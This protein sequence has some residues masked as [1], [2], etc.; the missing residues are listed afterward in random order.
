MA[1]T[2][3]VA[4][5]VV[6]GFLAGGAIWF[7]TDIRGLVGE[8]A[9]GAFGFE[10]G[11]FV[12]DF[13]WEDVDGRSGRF[14]DLLE[15]NAAVVV[16]LRTTE[17]PVSRRYGHRLAELEAEWADEGV[18]FLY[19]TVSPQD[20][21]EKVA[22]DREVYGFAGPY[23]RD[24]RGKIGAR[25]GARVSS[26]V[27]VFDPSGTLR[28][29]GP[30]DD[31]FGIDFSNPEVRNPWLDRAVGAVVEGRPVRT[32]SVE[33][34]G[35]HLDHVATQVPERE[36]TWHSR[37][38]RL[39]QT[40]CVS[41]H[42]EGGVA[43]FSLEHYEEAYG[44]RNMI[45]FVVEEGRMPPWFASPEHGAWRNDRSLS[46]RNRRDL[47]AWIAAGAPEGDPAQAVRPLHFTEGW[48]L[49]REPDHVFRIPEPQEVPASGVLDYRYLFVK[50]D[51]GEDV[52][53]QAMEPR[54]TAIEQVHHI[55]VYL[56]GPDDEQRGP[57]F[58]GWAP[59]TGAT[60]YPEGRAKV[61]PAD[62]WLMFEIHY[63][64]NGRPAVDES[65]VG[66][67]LSD[68]PPERPVRTAWVA[69]YDFEIP[70]H[71]AN[72]AVV[73]EQRFGRSGEILMFLPHMH[74]RGKAF[75]YELIRAD[76]TEEVLLDVPRYD[77]NW[78]LWY[79]AFEPIRIEAGDRIRAR[80]WYDNSNANPAN[81]DPTVAVQYGEQSFEEMMFGFFDW[82]PDP[83]PAQVAAAAEGDGE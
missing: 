82:V 44:F 35:C 61:L 76:G 14:S 46:E 83:P 6:A 58:A 12:A 11:E 52:W 17:C 8:D 19:L 3:L 24:E 15:D 20:T 2:P 78:Q 65:M 50:T 69:T 30:V 75:R 37:V 73:A 18:A 16:A 32:R 77:F 10:P 40:N 62:A 25:L 43:P 48:D 72:H 63:T 31:Q 64:P 54:P 49:P 5:V 29:R 26:E 66:F 34:S 67:I 4:G 51:F 9:P 23:V 71:A 47:L 53:I 41:C 68:G 38:S 42:R 1:K 81:P 70:P 7:G 13:A 60:I 21:P 59:G 39:V 55:I 36:I 45:S 28:Y 74:L 27:F 79:E 22:E 57:F 80:A 56:Q 33:A